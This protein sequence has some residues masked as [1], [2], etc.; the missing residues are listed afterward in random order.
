M[1]WFRRGP[2]RRR[3]RKIEVNDTENF[4]GALNETFINVNWAHDVL[5]QL[6]SLMDYHCETE[7]EY[8]EECD[9]LCGPDF[10]QR[11][12]MTDISEEDARYLALA[13]IKAWYQ[14]YATLRQQH[15][16]AQST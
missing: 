12:I 11:Y 3:N 9:I 4:L 16:E 1:K 13:A 10:I 15:G 5:T 8:V 14:C 2:A 7:H 6:I